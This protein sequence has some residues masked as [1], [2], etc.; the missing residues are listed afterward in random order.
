MQRGC[1][2]LAAALGVALLCFNPFVRAAQAQ[3]TVSGRVTDQATGQPLSGAR[4]IVVGATQQAT[5]GDDGRYTVRDVR[6]GAI[7]LQVLHVGYTS[8]KS[9]VTVAAGATASLDFAMTAAIVQLQEIVTTATGQQRKVELG[10]ALSTLGDVGK[11]VEQSEIST[12]A[13]LLTGKAPGVVVLPGSTLGGAPTIRV[14]GVSSISLPNDPIWVVDGVRISTGTLTSGTDTKFSLLNDLNPDDIEDIEIVKGPSAATLYGTDAANGVVVVTTKK[15]RAGASRWTYSGEMGNVDDRNDY[16]DMYANWGHTEANPTKN[17]R[18]QLGTMASPGTTPTSTTQCISDSVTHYNL[19]ADPSR[20]F[21][22]MGNRK[23][24]SAQVSGGSDAVRFFASGD[25]NNE[26]GPIQMP[27]FEVSRFAAA[28]TPAPDDWIHPLQQTAGSFRANLSASVSPTFD[29][30]A[31]AGFSKTD[32]H[33]EPESDLI[34]ALLYTGLQNYGYKG[35]PG[36]VAP[37][38]LDKIPTDPDGTPLNDYLQWAPGD[39]MQN[40]NENDVQRMIGSFNANWRPMPWMQNEGTVGVDLASV[41]YFSF[42][43]LNQCPPESATA[44]IGNI[45]DDQSDDR[46]LTAKVTS[47]SSWNFRPSVNFKTTLGADYVNQEQDAVNSSGQGLPPGASTVAAASSIS[48]SQLQPTATKTLGVYAQEQAS[49]RDKLFLTVAARSDQN[50]AFGTNFQRILYPKASASWLLSDES[51]FPKYNWMDQLRLRASYGASGVQPGRTSG[52]VLFSPGTVAI[53]GHSVTSE[54]DTRALS[55][56]NPGNSD[57]RPEKSAEME[58]GFDLQGLNNRMHFEYTYYNKQTHDALISVPIAGS[59]AAS[60][61]SILENVGS[62]RNYGQE[63]QLNA[64][65][66]DRR[67]FGWDVT[68]SGSHNTA[69]IVN[70]GIDPS[71]GVAR[72]IG[73]GT[74]TEQ[75][76]GQPIDNQWYYPYTYSDANHDGIIQVSE[77]HVADSLAAFGN[78]IPQDIF[79]VQTGFDLFKRRLRITSLFDYKGGYNTQDGADNFQCNSSPY[80][81]QSTEDPTASLAQQ[82]AAIAKTYGTLVNGTTYKSGAG[83]FMNGQFWRWREFS[84]IVQLPGVVNHALRA[85]DGSTVVFSA[86]NLHLWSSFWGIDPESNYG[87]TQSQ[88]QDEFQTAPPPTYFTLRVNLKY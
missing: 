28:G 27:G 75:R 13:D 17:V 39:V 22:H 6:Y 74:Q 60:T 50:S 69:L 1:W 20:T 15:G 73:A 77:V 72:V 52:L 46:D 71:T 56:S 21:L 11:T 48:A 79:S 16:P 42:C 2:K 30:N 78:N 85:Q 47:T 3:G 70:L 43:G 18:C 5:S 66:V 4:V 53:D 31:N 87:L 29:L 23:E 76:D 37:C 88:V 51:F 19:L 14:R 44:R 10:N 55:A 68:V 84:A 67:N 64:Q 38:G 86:R 9:S 12:T 8:K 83:Y 80:S 62:T 25:A 45:S 32:N 65:L 33:I 81:C 57:L 58:M 61:T 63:V 26:V 36:G 34:I 7:D 54:T 59:G 49:L 41:D 40:V 24:G 82:A 35:C